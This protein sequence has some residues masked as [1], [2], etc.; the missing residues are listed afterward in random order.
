[1]RIQRI[2]PMTIVTCLAAVLST[3]VLCYAQTTSPAEAGVS[4]RFR[5]LDRNGDGKVSAEEYPG[6]LFKQM[7]RDGDGFVTLE[8]AMRT[9]R[10]RR[11][12]IWVKVKE[13]LIEEGKLS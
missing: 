6:P 4:S 2:V 1:M 7:D 10:D 11:E 13:R 9:F 8:E 5:Q 12:K 3:V